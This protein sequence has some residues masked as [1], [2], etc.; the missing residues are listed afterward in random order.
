MND[1]RNRLRS[2]AVARL[3]GTMFVAHALLK[4]FVLG[5]GAFAARAVSNSPAPC[6]ALDLDTTKGNT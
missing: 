2:I 1:A 5:D 3:A 6:N 4:Y